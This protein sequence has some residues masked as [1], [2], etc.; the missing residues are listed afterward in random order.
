[1]KTA[2]IIATLV[3]FTALP[4]LARSAGEAKSAS[5]TIPIESLSQSLPESCGGE[6][7]S[8][9]GNVVL[10]TNIV[11]NASGGMDVKILNDRRQI[12]GATPTSTLKGIDTSVQNY[13]NS[14]VEDFEWIQIE[15]IP[16]QNIAGTKRA[17]IHLQWMFKVTASGD[18]S[19]QIMSINSDCGA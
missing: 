14:S 9:S 18:F 5:V 19:A 17:A 8:V 10:N 7:L 11:F 12:S 1:M 13:S 4:N 6:N 16:I 15:S 3:A 2:I